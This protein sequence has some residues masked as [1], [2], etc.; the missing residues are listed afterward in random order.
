MESYVQGERYPR[1]ALEAR[2]VQ[3]FVPANAWPGGPEVVWFTPHALEGLVGTAIQSQRNIPGPGGGPTESLEYK[4]SCG[5][6]LTVRH[7]QRV[8]MSLEILFVPDT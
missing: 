4:L 7:S 6:T 8:P 5:V 3:T 1:L 2:E